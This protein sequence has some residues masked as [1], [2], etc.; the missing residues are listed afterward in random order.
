MGSGNEIGNDL[1]RLYA[2]ISGHPGEWPLHYIRTWESFQIM[3][4]EGGTVVAFCGRILALGRW[5]LQIGTFRSEDENEY[6]YKF[7]VLSMRI[8]FGA[9]HFSKCACSEQKTRTRSCP[10]LPI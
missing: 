10:R 9:R 6:Q 5:N 3:F 4:P 8:G 2:L 1:I 7:S